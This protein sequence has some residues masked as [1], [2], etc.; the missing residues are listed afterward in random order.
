MIKD[1]CVGD[2]DG[3]ECSQIVIELKN[4]WNK[5]TKRKIK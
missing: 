4:I 5:R 3:Y 1:K 2:P